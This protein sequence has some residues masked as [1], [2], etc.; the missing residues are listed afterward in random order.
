MKKPNIVNKEEEEERREREEAMNEFIEI[1]YLMMV[2][3][4]IRLEEIQKTLNEDDQGL[5]DFLLFC[6]ED[7]AKRNQADISQSETV[8]ETIGLR[9]LELKENGVQTLGN[10]EMKDE[11]IL[12]E[13]YQEYKKSGRR[14]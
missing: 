12:N 14:E 9:E 2:R 13:L 6:V 3:T 5:F 1:K 4:A 8:N 11:D 7:F 10:G